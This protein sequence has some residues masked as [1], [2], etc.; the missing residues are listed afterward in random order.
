MLIKERRIEELLKNAD[1]TAYNAESIAATK[2]LAQLASE[3][4][5]K[6]HLGGECV[7]AFVDVWLK[8]FSSNPKDGRIGDKRYWPHIFTAADSIGFWNCS[9]PNTTDEAFIEN[10]DHLLQF[11]YARFPEEYGSFERA[12]ITACGELA[13]FCRA[14][15]FAL[16]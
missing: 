6:K 10:L 8:T 4:L 11:F 9:W 14:L 3:D 7:R 16:P 12:R 5:S 15:A 1:S 13:D 2:I